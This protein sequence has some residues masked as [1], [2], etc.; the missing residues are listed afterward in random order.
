MRSR[1]S[2]ALATAAAVATMATKVWPMRMEAA[3]S[4]PG[5]GGGT[6]TPPALLSL[7]DVAILVSGSEP[8]YVQFG[9]KDLGEYLGELSGHDV[10]VGSDAKTAMAAHAVVIVVGSDMANTLRISL[11]PERCDTGKG[12]SV[13]RSAAPAAPPSDYNSSYGELGA[14]QQRPTVVVIAGRDPRGTNAGIATF[15][16]LLAI[17]QAGAHV[18]A[19]LEVC[20]EPSF[21]TRGFHL[22]GWPVNYPYAFR[23]WQED[24]WKRFVDIAWAQRVNLFY[25]WPFMVS[26]RPRVL[27]FWVGT[28][29]LTPHRVPRGFAPGSWH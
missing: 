12:G 4:A 25:I 2:A 8:S 21:R 13:I 1:C 18:H 15:L 29:R 27:G 24:D 3:G 17:G 23:T 28:P 14:A 19:P 20:S 26:T 6:Q 7:T 22:N 10:A 9:A 16:R 11:I 5:H